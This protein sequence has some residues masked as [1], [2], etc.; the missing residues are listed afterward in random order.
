MSR[1]VSRA[2]SA[3]EDYVCVLAVRVDY[4][5]FQLGDFLS[6]R[7]DEQ[8]LL[9][10]SV[11]VHNQ[12][13]HKLACLFR[14][15]YIYVSEL[16]PFR[17]LVVGALGGLVHKPLDC[18]VNPVEKLGLEHT[19]VERNYPVAVIGKEAKLN[20][21][22]GIPRGKLSLVSVAVNPVVS[23][24]GINFQILKTADTLER[25]P[26]AAVLDF[27]L[28]FIGDVTVYAAAA[29]SENGTVNLNSVLRR[30]DNRLDFSV[31]VG[32]LGFKYSDLEVVADC[33]HRHKHDNAVLSLADAATLSRHRGYPQPYDIVLF[34]IHKINRQKSIEILY[35]LPRYLAIC[36]KIKKRYLFLSGKA[37]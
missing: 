29:F 19:V 27:K 7:L 3:S 35:H 32:F 1:A 11:S 26:D 16:A 33:R 23:R 4:Y 2:V 5:G 25:V 36:E 14:I 28:R 20:A 13:N 12:A 24:N 18:R 30:R 8:I 10:Q 9:L 34:Q 22:F 6:E 37:I 15:P 21:V 31:S 17:A